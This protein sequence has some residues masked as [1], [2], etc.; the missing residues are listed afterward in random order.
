MR[1]E[2]QEAR[3]LPC[4]RHLFEIPEEVVYFNCAYISPSLRAVRE[5]GERGVRRKSTPWLV[6]PSDFFTESEAARSAFARL[7]GATPADVAI[8]PSASYGIETAARNLPAGPGQEI[9]VLAEQFPSNVYPWRAL[10]ERSGAR[11][12][13]VPRDDAGGF[14][15]GLLAAIGPATAIAALPHCHWTDG[16][17]IDLEAVSAALRRVGAAL[18][19]DVSQSLGALPLDLAR[20]QPD[21]V[22]CAGYK[23]LLSPYSVSFLYAAPHRQAGEPLEHNW[24]ARAGA[25]DF[26]GLVAYRDEYAAGARRYDMGERANLC[27]MPM[28]LAALEQLL[29]WTPE[30]VAASLGAINRRIAARLAEAGAACTPEAG[31]APHFLGVRLPGGVPADLNARLAAAN[32]HVSVRGDSLRITP[33]L[34]VTAED[35]DRLCDV[36]IRE[37][38]LAGARP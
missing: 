13:T 34:H 14:T 19:L 24:I 27:L 36:L 9:L 18:V 29:D 11:L 6:Q 5:A 1:A 10:A 31:R 12:R 35:E 4:Q 28:A 16:T 15:A 3:P 2:P 32:V 7:I 21:F 37:A 30:A 23:W 26:R 17:L 22:A 25:E 8:V 38:G 33:H 20:V